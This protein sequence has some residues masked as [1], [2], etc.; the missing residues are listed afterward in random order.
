VFGRFVASFVDLLIPHLGPDGEVWLL[1][2]TEPDFGHGDGGACALLPLLN[3]LL[4]QPSS[5]HPGFSRENPKS[6]S[7]GSDDSDAWRR[8]PLEDLIFYQTL[9]GGGSEVERRAS[10]LVYDGGS[11]WRGAVESRQRA[12]AAV[13]TQGGAAVRRHGG[14]I[15]RIDEV[16]VDLNLEADLVV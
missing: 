6:G 8:F 10:L 12:R 7:P 2:K 9:A 4:L 16:Y 13:R 15:R 5:P 11:R 1:V 3:A 14:I